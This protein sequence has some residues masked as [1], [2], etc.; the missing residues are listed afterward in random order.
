[1]YYKIEKYLLGLILVFALISGGCSTD[2]DNTDSQNN[3]IVFSAA[4]TTNAITEIS[5]LFTGETG[6]NVTTNFAS[7]SALAQQIE[8]GADADIFISA[9]QK[10]ADELE[11]KQLVAKR[12]TIVGNSIVIILP[13][14]ST[15]SG[16]SPE[17]LL[18][19]EVRTISMGEPSSVPAGTY[20]K[21]ALVKLG[22]W[23]KIEGKV[24]SAKDVRSALAYV[25]TS[26][27]EAGI[28]YSTDAAISDKVKTVYTFPDDA[29]DKPISYPAMTLTNAVNEKNADLFFDFLKDSKSKSVFE[30]YGFK[31]ILK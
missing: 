16:N 27:A 12:E 20:G 17:I 31:I 30:K 18:Q 21:K 26:A 22:L 15:I 25:E 2:S 5:D 28:V 11:K 8:F 3:V 29:V 9:N 4:S 10:W 6:I 24:V 1:M 19:P 7:A 13:D 14:G 23:E